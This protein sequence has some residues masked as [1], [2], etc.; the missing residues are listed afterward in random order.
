MVG[1]IW[2]RIATPIRGL[3]QAA[4]W[5]AILTL[6]SQALALIR[7]R[8]FAHLFGASASLDL[9]YA[10]F[11]IPDLV[12]TLVASLVSAYVLIPRLTGASKDEAQTLISHAVSFLLIVGGVVAVIIALIA[13][14]ILFII[15]PSFASS[16]QAP[17]FVMLVRLLLLQPILLGLSGIA[18][19]VTQVHRRFIIYSLSPVLYNLGII[20]GALVLYPRFGLIGIGYGVILGSL[21]YLAVHVP[22]V[23]HARLLPRLVWPSWR[24]M[25]LVMRDSVPRALALG[26]GT[27]VVFIITVL[28]ARAGTGVIS[29]FT[30]A[31]NLEA[32]PLA[33]IGSSYAVAAFPVLSE[34]SGQDNHQ[35][36]TRV[37][38]A[39]GRHLVLWSIVLFALV[40]VL[41]AHLVR[42]ILGTGQFNWND[43]R[44]TAAA[45]AILVVGLA[46]QGLI[47]LLSR[48]L[49]A[50]RQS[51]RPLFYQ[52]AGGAVS[53]SIAAG[54]LYYLH[55]A[56][57][58]LTAFGSLFRVGDVS[59]NIV[60]IFALA[61]VLGQCV[62]TLCLMAAMR[63][64]A[65]GF[66]RALARPIL[67]GALAA[68]AGGSAAYGTLAVMGN[69]ASLT[70]LAA[71]FTQGL[72]A[73]MVG[74]VT[75]GVALVLLQNKEFKDIRV[76]VHRFTKKRG[77][78][79]T[80]GAS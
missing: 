8:T 16:S 55:R 58:T 49:Y 10:A 26:V 33:L 2:K 9:Y 54:G 11:K 6:A 38:S 45:L 25:G 50:A 70:T 64:V 14:N 46:A 43:T 68:L 5:L 79:P 53:V 31:T 15:F 30:F 44:L 23:A 1:R 72:V 41:R 27:A 76:A 62:T 48:A 29:V 47:L 60:L 65:P 32:V 7:D 56:P 20:F 73:G 42:I 39:A 37:L 13:P 18:A 75:T 4:Y 3:H 61:T 80:F 67:E 74:L 66:N 77:M 78:P 40:V 36:F 12:F 35:E 24:V 28:A 19:S 57:S 22:I 51:W 63:T 71:V 69:I 52:L 17:A 59:G 34:L 21:A